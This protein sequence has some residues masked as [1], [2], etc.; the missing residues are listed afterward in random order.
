VRTPRVRSRCRKTS[1]PAGSPSPADGF[2]FAG[3]RP[4]GCL[5]VHGFTATPDEMRPLGEALA[6]RGFPVRGVRLAGHGTDVADLARTS[7]ADWFATVAE[8]ADRLLRDVPALAVAGMS[9]GA[10]LALH[11]AAT[12][13]RDVAALVLCGTPLDLGDARL[14]WLP[15]LARVPWIARRWAIMPKRNGPDIADPVMRAASRSYPAMPLAGVLE[16]LRLQALVRGEI[17]RVTQPALLLHGRHDHSVPLAN[18]ELVRRSLASRLVESHVLERSW[19]V[20]TLDYDR[21]EVARLTADFLERVAEGAAPPADH[22]VT[23][24]PG[25]G[26]TTRSGWPM[27][28]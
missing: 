14:R 10:L 15:L 16:L 9:L 20:V 6:A 17:G 8:G 13:P 18:L 11:L 5:L 2:A 3:A 23:S 7:W 22:P 1:S 21:D 27:G 26:K 4:L 19:H 25:V 12:R 28:G 24:T